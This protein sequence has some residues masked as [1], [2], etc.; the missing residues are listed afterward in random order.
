MRSLNRQRANIV[1]SHLMQ[2]D[3]VLTPQQVSRKER[4]FEKDGVLRWEDNSVLGRGLIGIQL[5]ILL[6]SLAPSHEKTGS[7]HLEATPLS[8][9]LRLYEHE[10][11]ILWFD[12]PTPEALIVLKKDCTPLSQLKA[13]SQALL[14]ASRAAAAGRLRRAGTQPTDDQ[15]V[16]KRQHSPNPLAELRLTLEQTSET[17]D[18]YAKRLQDAG[19]DL[20]TAALETQ[21]GTRI[22]TTTRDGDVGSE[23]H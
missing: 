1:F 7:L 9:L 17:F 12:A 10:S 15:H 18:G 6:Q 23:K 2:H 8:E 16:I 5:S 4:I 19:W 21:S 22:T 11:Y 3:T 14:L 20:H 13:W